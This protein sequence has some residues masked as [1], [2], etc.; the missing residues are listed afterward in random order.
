MR[1][2]KAKV[3]E[4]K[5]DAPPLNISPREE[6]TLLF[7]LSGVTNKTGSRKGSKPLE[8]GVKRGQKRPAVRGKFSHVTNCGIKARVVSDLTRK[9]NK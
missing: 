1:N 8:L 5:T 6:N 4:I 2:G 3:P 9:C 7:F